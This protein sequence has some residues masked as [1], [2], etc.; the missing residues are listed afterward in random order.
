[1]KIKVV[2]IF[3]LIS[4][5]TSCNGTEK[6]SEEMEIQKARILELEAKVLQKENQVGSLQHE[7]SETMKKLTNIE[8]VNEEI[9]NKN[10]MLSQRFLCRWY[11]AL[12]Y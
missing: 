8:G 10:K 4:I 7:L 6:V 9:T 2:V 1:M 12:F 11:I 3:I 5:L